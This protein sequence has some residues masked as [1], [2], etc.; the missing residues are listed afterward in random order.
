MYGMEVLRG[1]LDKHIA[2]K[3]MRQGRKL[4]SKPDPD[5]KYGFG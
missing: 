5:T 1:A 3:G 2:D 4:A